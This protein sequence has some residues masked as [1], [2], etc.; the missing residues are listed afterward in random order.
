MLRSP[1]DLCEF[2][3]YKYTNL[4]TSDDSTVERI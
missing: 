2:G 3:W 4:P 1:F